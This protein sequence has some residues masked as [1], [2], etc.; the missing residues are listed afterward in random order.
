MTVNELLKRLTG[1]VEKDSS[2]GDL[3][4]Y[5]VDCRSGAM[6]TDC[7]VFVDTVRESDL[8]MSDLDSDDVGTDYL[9]INIG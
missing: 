4:I 9:S 1:L 5:V 2:V 8:D 6:E 7:S 3:P